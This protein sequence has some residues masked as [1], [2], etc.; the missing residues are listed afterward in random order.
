MSL[1]VKKKIFRKGTL[2]KMI[3]PPAALINV[4]F[5]L[6]LLIFLLMNFRRTHRTYAVKHFS[7]FVLAG[8]LA[9]PAFA[10]DSKTNAADASAQPPGQF[11]PASAAVLTA[12]L[13]L[14]NDYIF[15]PGDQAEVTNGGSAIFNFTVTNAGDYVIETLI[16]APA[17]NSNSFFA[18]I[19][20]QPTDPD[21]IWDMDITMGFEKRVLS[22]RGNGD[23]AT[24]QFA[25]K[26]FTLTA[27]A[28][29]LILI[30]RE[31]DTE[32]KSLTIRPAPP[33]PPAAP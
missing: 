33:Q 24:D 30:G 8:A 11:F 21:M 17:D 25:P 5:H 20:D 27:G 10:Q 22:W 4:W 26:R 14:T 9:I 31:P 23:S 1:L 29:K 16:N 15:L 13:V 12:P 3:R 2:A 6:V 19:D 32:L 7:L 18:N 28:H